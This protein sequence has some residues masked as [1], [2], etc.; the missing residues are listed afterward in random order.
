MEVLNYNST[1]VYGYVIYW[2]GDP[3]N[4]DSANRRCE[5]VCVFT[6]KVVKSLISIKAD[7]LDGGSQTARPA[8]EEKTA[9][10]VKMLSQGSTCSRYVL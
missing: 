6:F 8:Q 4:H 2:S 3:R 1:Q 5:N 10:I 9:P 7:G